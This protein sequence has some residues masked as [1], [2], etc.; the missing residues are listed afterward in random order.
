MRVIVNKDALED[1]IKKILEARSIQSTRIDTIAGDIDADIDEDE[2]PIQPTDM[3]SLQLAVEMPPVS[4]PEFIPATIS[5]LANSASVISREV[6]SDQIGFFYRRLHD[7]LD[8]ALDRHDA[9]EWEESEYQE[10][11]SVQEEE[12]EAVEAQGATTP[13]EEDVIQELKFRKTVSLILEDDDTFTEY[14]LDKISVAVEEI[15]EFL[16]SVN[17]GYSTRERVLSSGEI[18]TYFA[19][20]L[21]RR[22]IDDILDPSDMLPEIAA[23]IDDLSDSEKDRVLSDVRENY[24]KLSR[25]ITTQ[26]DVDQLNA[27]KEIDMLANNM[28][29]SM[30]VEDVVKFLLKK[31]KS[32]K[33]P[34]KKNAYNTIANLL[35]KK[36]EGG[37]VDA[38]TYYE[39]EEEQAQLSPEDAAKVAQEKLERDLKKLDALATV[40]GFSAASGFRQ[41]RMKFPE[42]IFKAVVGSEGGISEY[43]GFADE[44]YKSMIL[45][46]RKISEMV[47]LLTEEVE[48][49]LEENPNDKDLEQVVEA[50]QQIDIDLLEIRETATDDGDF[51]SEMANTT[52]GGKV[53]KQIF[54][55]YFYKPPFTEYAR[56]MKKHMIDFLTSQGINQKTASTF[57]KMFNGEVDLLPYNS[58]KMQ[59]NKIRLGGITPEIYRASLVEAQRF[60]KGFF[61][62]ASR[63][64]MSAKFETMLRDP[65][66]ITRAI[67]DAISDVFEWSATE[68]ESPQL[69]VTETKMRDL[70]S[71][72]I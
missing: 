5:E 66:K 50:L 68:S 31:E 67:F 52:L 28:L 14:E 55:T 25:T 35:L 39:E 3:M 13:E 49:D 62:Q 6:P 19:G 22:A 9:S 16:E 56:T 57:A 58:Q 69:Q 8:Q 24:M 42:P 15:I 59:M 53:L 60:T 38:P 72:I 33:D 26:A 36:G 46:M 1:A 54:S 18:Q 29:N 7:L 32:E 47:A 12:E 30:S 48:D 34:L 41:W 2:D 44:V 63:E 10:E 23:A 40:F 37:F 21:M 64:E 17:F 51:D 71:G 43:R 45:A 65:Q 27:N 61:G 70:I 20:G 11:P 4:D